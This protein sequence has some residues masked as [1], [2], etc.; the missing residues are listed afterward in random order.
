MADIQI[1]I[2]GQG[3][4]ALTGAP[5]AI[6]AAQDLFTDC[7]LTGNYEIDSEPGREGTVTAMI[8]GIGDNTVTA[9]EK[10]LQWY[11]EHKQ[12]KSGQAIEKAVIVGQNGQRLLLEDAT[13]AEI[14]Q[15]LEE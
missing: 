6:A 7:G 13:L 10:I 11:Q 9:A 2:Q 8:I 4:I 12:D 5:S 15:I 1:E 14:G 3:A